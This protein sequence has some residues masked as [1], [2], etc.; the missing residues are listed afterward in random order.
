MPSDYKPKPPELAPCETNPFAKDLVYPKGGKANLKTKSERLKGNTACWVTKKMGLVDKTTGEVLDESVFINLRK[1]VDAEAFIKFYGNGLAAV[2]DLS[3]RAQEVLRYLLKSYNEE[4]L[5]GTNDLVY[6]SFNEA[7]RQG[8]PRK[9]Q[10]WRSA[11]NELMYQEFMVPATKGTDWFW[12]NPTLFYRGDRL[13]IINQF[14]KKPESAAIEQQNQ[15]KPVGDPVLDQMDLTDML[16]ERER[17][18][19]AGE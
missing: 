6:F 13:T 17:R 11:M 9:R 19:Q 16:T 8:Y 3:K 5:S 1:T 15:D 2:F 10:T 4:D 18:K 14:I 12:I 7:L